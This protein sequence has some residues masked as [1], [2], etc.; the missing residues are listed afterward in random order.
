MLPRRNRL[1]SE[2]EFNSLFKSGKTF[3][4]DLLIMKL[5]ARTPEQGPTK[6]GFA[7]GLKFSK[8]ASLRNQARRWLREATRSRVKEIKP[9]CE[10]IFAIKPFQKIE[11]LNLSKI[12]KSV[13][14]LL[15]K[16]KLLPMQE[17]MTS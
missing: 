15:R 5:R 12:E 13:N 10:I 2:A 16:A 17:E 1:K 7:V 9:G 3:T 11:K 8:K 6:I 14:F 4:N